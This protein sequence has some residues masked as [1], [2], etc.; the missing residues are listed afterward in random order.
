MYVPAAL[1]ISKSELCVYGF[2]TI[3]AVNSDYFLKQHYPVDL[4]N[5]EVLFSL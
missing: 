4:C 2:C 5:G 1:T 3:L